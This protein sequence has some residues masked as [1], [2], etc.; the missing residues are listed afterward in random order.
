VTCTGPGCECGC[1]EGVTAVTPYAVFNRPGLSALAWRV[2][3]HSDFKESM[4]ARIS[5]LPALRPL[6]TRED[7]DFSVALMD[8]WA[9]ALDVLTFY[10]ERIANEGFLRTATERRSLLEL[11]REIGYEPRP[12]VAASVW[13]AFTLEDSPGSPR[14]VVIPAR[15]RALSLPVTEDVPQPFETA[16][17]LRA[18]PEWNAIR[19]R[20]SR[21]QALAAAA[22]TYYFQG[23]ET[24]LAPGSRLLV[25]LSDATDLRKVVTVEP[26]A[27]A[28]RTK[29]SLESVSVEPVKPPALP[30]APGE[31]YSATF[32]TGRQALSGVSAAASLVGH[33]WRAADFTAFAETRAWSLDALSI[34]LP[35]LINLAPATVPPVGRPAPGVYALRVTAA[36]FGYNAPLYKTLP[37]PPTVPVSVFK[38]WDTPGFPIGQSSDSKPYGSDTAPVLYL[39]SVYPGIVAGSWVALAAPGVGPKFWQV[40]TSDEIFATDFAISAKVTRLVLAVSTVSGDLSK[41]PLRTTAVFA[42]SEPLAL[43]AEPVTAPFNAG[44][45]KIDLAGLE[46]GL[47]PG[48]SL[49]LTGER[50]DLPDVIQSELV[51]LADVYPDTTEGFTWLV[52]A[53]G[54]ENAWRRETV[55]LNANVV[56]ANHGETVAEVMGSGDAARPFQRFALKEGPLTWT[57]APVA[58]GAESSLEVRV[59][60]VLWHEAPSLYG[61]GPGDRRYTLRQDDAGVTRVL[62]GDGVHGARLHT[63]TDNVT[64]VY[65]KGIGLAGLVDAGRISLLD[66]RPLGVDEVINPLPSAG[67]ADREAAAEI[68]ANAPLTVLTLDRIVSLSDHEDFARSFSGIGKAAAVWLLDGGVRLVHVTVAAAD[69]GAVPATSELYRNLLAAMRRLRDPFQPLRVDTFDPVTFNL[70]LNVLVDPDFRPDLVLPAVESALR[71]TFSFAARDFAQGVALSEVM[72]VAQKVEGVVAVD[73]DALYFSW[74]GKDHPSLQTRLP[75]LPARALPGGGVAPAQHLSLGSQ[76]LELGILKTPRTA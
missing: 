54:L 13:L 73:V 42:L 8:A 15:T 47:Y 52:L 71:Q 63:G 45:S 43:A 22:D 32:L 56:L 1:C 55:T 19:A 75:A 3:R 49:I 34:A 30:V 51:V 25:A 38:N 21:R 40:V 61:L 70:T 62:F 53:R 16:E 26:D 60:D 50:A 59:D 37:T 9:A 11:A 58:S 29:V 46:L 23:V 74:Q 20:T 7:D 28:G 68:R 39:D 64:A 41:F 67:A 76:G 14:E 35:Q 36:G 27:D 17:D 5:A 72:A 2:G 24:G 18:R 48:R 57:S 4:L 65:Q 10:Q 69:G 66:T 12:G 31:L 6:T 44:V 33:T